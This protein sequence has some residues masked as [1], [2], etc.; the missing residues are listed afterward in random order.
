MNYY[1]ITFNNTE[2][3][4]SVEGLVKGNNYSEAL[5]RG[6]TFLAKY[7]NEVHKDGMFFL[8]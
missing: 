3:G 2:I 7:Q 8:G 5:G 4:F 6:I 1:Y